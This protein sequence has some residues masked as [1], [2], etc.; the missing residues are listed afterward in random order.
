MKLLTLAHQTMRSSSR[1]ICVCICVVS[2][3][4][5]LFAEPPRQFSKKSGFPREQS[6]VGP[7]PTQGSYQGCPCL[8]FTCLVCF[9][10]AFVTLQ[11]VLLLCLLSMSCCPCLVGWFIYCLHSVPQVVLDL[12]CGTGILSVFSACLGDSRKVHMY[13]VCVHIIRMYCKFTVQLHTY[14]HSN[15][16][17][18]QCPYVHLILVDMGLVGFVR[19]ISFNRNAAHI[20]R[21]TMYYCMD[22]Q[23]WEGNECSWVCVRVCVCVCACVCVCVGVCGCGCVWVWVLACVHVCNCSNMQPQTVHSR[24]LCPFMYVATLR[25][26]CKVDCVLDVAL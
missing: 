5:A 9:F 8:L 23:T 19:E 24:L 6:V 2:Q 22:T 20:P 12:G 21:G 14:V 17:G 18:V 25:A 11:C 7:T 3:T 13:I 26:Q 10:V 16:A 4:L 15:G 1:C